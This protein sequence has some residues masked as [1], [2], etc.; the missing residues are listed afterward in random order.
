MQIP[1]VDTAPQG[2]ETQPHW[3]IANWLGL[4]E[5]ARGES[6][7][8]GQRRGPAAPVEEK[9]PSSGQEFFRM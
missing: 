4:M 8:S 5:Q 7:P 1:R 3:V 2:V 6:C 9:F